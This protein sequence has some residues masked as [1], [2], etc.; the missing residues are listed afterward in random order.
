M[1]R[2]FSLAQHLA[3]AQLLPPAADAAGRTS[4][5]LN[6]GKGHKAWIVVHVSQ[7]NAATIALTPLQAKDVSGTG[8]KA[9]TATRIWVDSNEGVSDAK[10][11]QSPNAAN[12]TTDAGTN[13]KTV[14]F[15]ILPEECMDM[16]NGFH[17][18]AIQTGPSNAANITE[19]MLYADPR[20]QQAIPPTLL[21]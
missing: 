1:A 18:V 9:I 13:N 16:A 19:A 11:L 12:F 21:T 7:G 8:S 6:V 10:V 14:I 20:F 2:Q 5:Y 4:N 3:I 15:E 17:T